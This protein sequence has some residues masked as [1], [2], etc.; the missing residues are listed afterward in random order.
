MYRSFIRSKLEAMQNR[1]ELFEG[2]VAGCAKEEELEHIEAENKVLD[3]IQTI[4]QFF[5]VDY[6]SGSSSFQPSVF[7]SAAITRIVCST[8]PRTSL[9]R[10]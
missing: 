8:C 9:S 6:D 10:F 5:S 3:M 2:L 4:L 7:I 1:Q